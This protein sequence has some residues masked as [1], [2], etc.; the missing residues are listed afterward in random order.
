MA[1]KRRTTRRSR[2]PAPTEPREVASPFADWTFEE[3]KEQVGTAVDDLL[4][5][6]TQTTIAS[7]GNGQRRN[8][9][10]VNELF[11]L[12]DHWQDG[13]GW[14]GPHPQPDEDGFTETMNEIEQAFVSRNV[15]GEVVERHTSFLLGAEPRWG[16]VPRRAM[17][18]GKEPTS[19]EQALIDEAEAALTIWWDARRIHAI[20]QDLARQVVWASRSAFRLYVPP[21]MLTAAE[22]SGRSVTTISAKTLDEALAK[23]WPDHPSY[24]QATVYEDEDTKQQ[25]GIFLFASDDELDHAELSF[26]QGQ[27]TIIRQMSDRGNREIDSEVSL[28][29]GGRLPMYEITRPL[30]ITEQIQRAQRALNLAASMLPR[31]VV[32]GGFLER[33]LLNAQMPGRW[34]TDPKGNPT[35]FV[36]SEYHTGSGS[37]NFITGV[38]Y[39]DEEGKTILATPDIRWREPIPVQPAVDAKNEHYRDILEEA[40]QGHII[41]GTD[42]KLGW[43]SREQLR[44]DSDKALGLTKTPTEQCG[45]WLLETALAMAEAFMGAPGRYTSVLRAEFSCL[46]SSGPLSIDERKEN[47]ESAKDGFLSRATTMERNGVEDVDAELGRMAGEPDARADLA[48]KQASALKTLTDAGASLEG[49]AQFLGI[50][51]DRAKLLI[52]TDVSGGGIT[53]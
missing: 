42:P 38:Q 32:T 47:R 11:V 24:A 34:E 31:N 29:L 6:T 33:V 25:L 22:R 10:E 39:K 48:V 8:L 14:V 53:Q 43:K 4:V 40:K 9:I 46:A 36:P 3:A 19:E 52:T 15:I 5:P 35:K 44:A 27:K 41:A 49:A 23:L 2:R 17:E 7:L 28:P 1:T 18:E 20:L 51:E 50:P 45:R 30:L 26:V 13:N 16:L 21:G 37:T 12:G